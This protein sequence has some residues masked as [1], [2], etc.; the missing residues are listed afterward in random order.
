MSAMV[1]SAPLPRPFVTRSRYALG[2]AALV[3]GARIAA[4]QTGTVFG[5]VSDRGSGQ[6]ID[7][8]RAQVVGTS[9][10]AG[11][12]SRGAFVLRRSVEDVA[13]ALDVSRITV[14]NYLNAMREE[15]ARRD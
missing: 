3:L 14:Y 8:A 10:V 6:P 11:T 15:P 12:D 13:D 4:A 5:T 9:I 1:R 2:F 7:A